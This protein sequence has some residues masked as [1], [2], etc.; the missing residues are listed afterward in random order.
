MVKHPRNPKRRGGVFVLLRLTEAI[1]EKSMENEIL[2][3]YYI[4]CQCASAIKF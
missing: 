3:D 2:K 4:L 1:S